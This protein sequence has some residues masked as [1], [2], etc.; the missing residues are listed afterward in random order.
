M[1]GDLVIALLAAAL[2]LVDAGVHA[3]ALFDFRSRTRD[4]LSLTKG[5]SITILSEAVDEDG[6][7]HGQRIRD[8]GKGLVPLSHVRLTVPA[9]DKFSVAAGS[10]FS[11]ALKKALAAALEED[12]D[13]SADPQ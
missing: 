5:E 10:V 8:G 7:A 4:E 6:W 1:K 3:I 13:P 11:T 2:P 12:D 9:D